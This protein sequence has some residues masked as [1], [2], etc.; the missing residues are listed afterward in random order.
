MA[1]RPCDL[2]PP[3]VVALDPEEVDVEVQVGL[4]VL[5]VHSGEAPEV[6]LEPRA[7]VVHQL[8]RLQVLRVPHVRLVGL[9]RKP[10]LPDEGAMGPLAVV[11]ERRALRDVAPERRPD[12][13]GGG[14]AV[15]ADHRD[16]LLAGVDAH[17]Y[18]QLLL[19][20]LPLARLPVSLGE[21]RVV[22]AGLVDPDAAP[23][24]DAVLVAVDGGEQAVAPLPG[25]MVADC[26]RPP[27]RRRAARRTAPA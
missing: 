7:Q 11:D 23:Q 10:V 22:D 2:G 20:Q 14:P 17:R 21:V 5:G 13:G 6:A 1:D 24:H 26:G 3:L 8:H 12:A 18:A 19:G 25:G 27:R 9:I 16:G 4:Q 15:P